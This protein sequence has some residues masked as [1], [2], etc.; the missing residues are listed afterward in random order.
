MSQLA[1]VGAGGVGAGLLTLFGG[2]LLTAP[3]APTVQPVVDTGEVFSAWPGDERGALDEELPPVCTW[4][5]G[6]V[7]YESNMCSAFALS[8]LSSS[9]HVRATERAL[10]CAAEGETECVL[11]PEIGVSVP[12][13]FLYDEVDGVRML[14]APRMLPHES[15]EVRVRVQSPLGGAGRVVE[16]NRS[17]MVEYLPGGSRAPVTE[18]LNGSSAWCVQLLR[19]VFVD[20]CWEHLD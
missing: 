15:E 13:A 16:M 20:E 10:R 12:A 18:L 11:S 19:Q 3:P 9:I 6:S 2:S 1:T 4:T 8:R 17:V 7:K 5:N 14:V